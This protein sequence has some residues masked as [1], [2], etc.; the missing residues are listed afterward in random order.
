MGGGSYFDGRDAAGLDGAVQEAFK[1]TFEV[2]DASQR[3]VGRGVVDGD[4]LELMPG[5]YTVRA[6]GRTWTAEVD[7]GRTTSVGIAS[8]P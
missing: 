1:P 3:S 7:E 5:T 8:G 6:R 2:I 4:P